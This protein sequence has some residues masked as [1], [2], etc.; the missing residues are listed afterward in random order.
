MLRAV[1]SQRS[2]ADTARARARACVCVWWGLAN[3]CG[4]E[5]PVRGGM[6]ENRVAVLQKRKIRL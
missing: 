3:E 5:A 6:T 4:R 1:Y 2:R